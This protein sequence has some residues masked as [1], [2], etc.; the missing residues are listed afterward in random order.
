MRKDIKVRF[1][2]SKEYHTISLRPEKLTEVQIINNEVFDTIDE[3][4]IEINKD[5]YNKLFEDEN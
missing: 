3:T 2:G 4:R 5:D 1:S